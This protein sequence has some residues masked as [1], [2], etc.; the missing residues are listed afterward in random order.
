MA[1]NDVWLKLGEGRGFLATL[2][3]KEVSDGLGGESDPVEGEIA[4]YEASPA[5]GSKL[6]GDQRIAHRGLTFPVEGVLL[7]GIYVADQK[8]TKKGD[9]GAEYEV[10]I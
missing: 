7:H 3:F 9:H 2:S 5:G 8:N 4:R 1:N 6:D 10:G